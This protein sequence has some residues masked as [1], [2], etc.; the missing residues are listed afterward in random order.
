MTLTPALALPLALPLAGKAGRK[1]S[2]SSRSIKET[3]VD[4]VLRGDTGEI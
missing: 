4:Q 1:Q 2:A 3:E